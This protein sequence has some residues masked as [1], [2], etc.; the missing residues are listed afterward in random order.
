MLEKNEEKNEIISLKNVQKKFHKFKLNNINFSVNKGYIMGIIGK[1]GAG[2]TT[3]MKIMLGVY[4]KSNGS[5]QIDG[6]ELTRKNYRLHQLIG[7]IS[8]DHG[9]LL[10]SSLIDNARI[11]GKFYDSFDLD[12]FL[13]LLEK[14]NLDKDKPLGKLSKGMKTKFQLAFTLAYKP[15]LLLLDEPT[16]GLDPLFR[17]EFL[18]ILQELVETEEMGIIISTHITTDLDKIADYIMILDHGEMISISTKEELMDRY[19]IVKGP[20]ELLRELPKEFFVSVKGTRT[21][22]EGLAYSDKKIIASED[23]LKNVIVEFPNLSDILYYLT[24]E[25]R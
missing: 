19:R 14:W 9:F 23:K 3:L 20:V 25:R 21:S 17:Q 1:N 24:K 10:S 15:R 6:Q 7:F 16:G 18:R 13:E 2:K 5:I 11:F 12:Y 22:F 8:E 4:R